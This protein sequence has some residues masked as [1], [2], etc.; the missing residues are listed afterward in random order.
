MT[1]DQCPSTRGSISPETGLRESDRHNGQ[2]IWRSLEDHAGTPEFREFVEREFPKGA[3]ELLEQSR[4]TFVKLMGASLALAGAA[5]LPGC[6]RP[7]HKILTYS[8]QV[9]EEVVIGKPLYYATSVALS[10]GG[11]A[12]LLI[13][14]H[15]GRPTKIEGNPL[16]P[17]NRGKADASTIA[18]ILGLYD[19][20]RLKYPIYNNPAKGKLE[21]TWD[22]FAQ[23]AKAEFIQK[24][25]ND[26]GAG[27]AIIADQVDSPSRRAVRE[28]LMQRYPQA[29][30]V[31]HNS[32]D[33]SN[34]RE[35]SR[36][37]FGQPMRELLNLEKA[38]VIVSF[39]RDLIAGEAGAVNHARAIASMRRPLSSDDPMSR[40]Y[41]L[42]SGFSTLGGIADHRVALSPSRITAF[43]LLLATELMTA[44][45][46]LFQ[47]SQL[48]DAV[49]AVAIPQADQFNAL[50]T[51]S[52][53]SFI[54]AVADDLISQAHLGHSVLVAGNTQP[55]AI[56]ALVHAINFALG[57]AGQT[58]QYVT[59]TTP[60]ASDFGALA[61]KIRAGSISTLV[62]INTNPLYDAPR[63][64]NFAE[65]MATVPNTITL[66]VGQNETALASTWSLNAAHALESWGDTESIDGTIAPTQPMIAPLYEPAKSDIEF[67][68][69]LTGDERADGYEIVRTAWRSRMR[70]ATGDERFEKAWRRALHDGVLADSAVQPRTPSVRTTTLVSALASLVVGSVP[71]E[72]ALEVSFHTGVIGDGRD[73]NNAWLQELPDPITKVVWDNPALVS[74]ATAKALGLTAHDNPSKVYTKGQ[75][76]QARMA[77]ITIGDRSMEIP[78]WVCP[79][80]ADNTVSLKLGY[81]RS[82]AGLVGDDVGFDVGRVRPGF[83]FAASGV[84][85]ERISGTYPISSTQNH[86]SLEGRTAIARSL[87]HQVYAEHVKIAEAAGRAFV[88]DPFVTQAVAYKGTLHL[89]EQLGELSHTP[90]SVSAYTNPLNQSKANAKEGSAFAQ[91]L[92]WGMVI[93]M[94]TCTG[95]NACTIACQSE[96]NIPVVGKDEVAKGRE[97]QWIRVDRYFVGDDIN[98]PSKLINQPIACVHC[99]NA[100]CEVVCPVNATVHDEEGLN[101]MAYN[102]CIG[103]RYCMN[104]CPYKVRRFNFFDWGQTKYNGGLDPRFATEALAEELTPVLQDNKQTF[105]QNFI[106]PRLRAK[107][108]EISKMKM[109]PDVTV[110]GRGVMEKCTYCIQRINRARYEM[111]LQ[112]LPNIP[113]GF[114]QVACQQACPSDAIAFGDIRDPSSQVSTL[115]H[116]Q[117]GYLLL[118]YLNTRPRTTHLVHLTNPNPAIRT[119]YTPKAL[120]HSDDHHGGDG[121]DDLD[122]RHNQSPENPQVRGLFR[123]DP[124]KSLADPGYA[125]S[126]NVLGANA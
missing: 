10:G 42:E 103:T 61:S 47:G 52:E 96:N 32:A 109:N 18:S 55:P 56:H 20:D 98:A 69:M 23:W 22:D 106:P 21:A 90:A 60:E 36:M 15:E 7:D 68:A 80:M 102:R 113:D 70:M 111:K 63:T 75:E 46:E 77:R 44:R 29:T 62:C 120:H 11:A 89:G 95:C 84:K 124:S 34:A 3:S 38:K 26:S 4:R 122:L 118:Q 8:N 78:V 107:L 108:D 9:P 114:F 50:P 27:L 115:R 67:I 88:E 37:V 30:W 24:H 116:N 5:T 105:N 110:R 94:A 64:M 72:S 83:D 126:L 58:V 39:D 53:I 19:P 79:G 2:K 40:I 74:P 119:P 125:L 13:E 31:F 43:A 112:D 81:G 35:G 117:R 97:M 51:A 48:R 1:I 121:H 28:R 91:G 41:C 73:A 65:L 123:H 59:D 6:R 93:D 25:Q 82:A 87:D 85:L 71:T 16:H 100:P 49:R 104:N 45:P 12:G 76:P 99:E 54:K 92:Q 17:A 86:W 57:N 66:A 33:A 101:V 14:T